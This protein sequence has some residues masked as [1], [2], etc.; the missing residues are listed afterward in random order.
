MDMRY[1]WINRIS[2]DGNEVHITFSYSD[3]LGFGSLD[4]FKHQLKTIYD[5]V[6]KDE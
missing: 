4:M 2:I 3:S 1:K 6:F 5:K